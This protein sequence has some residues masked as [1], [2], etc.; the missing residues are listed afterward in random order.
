MLVFCLLFC[1]GVGG[2]S[3]SNFL[4]SSVMREVFCKFAGLMQAFRWVLHGGDYMLTVVHDVS[5]L[6]H[7]VAMLLLPCRAGWCQNRGIYNSKG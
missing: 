5:F 4:A 2:R 6:C 3:C 1:L 7:G